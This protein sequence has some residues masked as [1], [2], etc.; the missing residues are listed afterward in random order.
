MRAD[1]LAFFFLPQIPSFQVNFLLGL[2]PLTKYSSAQ[3]G[4][5]RWNFMRIRNTKNVHG[6][7]TVPADFPPLHTIAASVQT[8]FCDCQQQTGPALIDAP[9]SDECKAIMLRFKTNQKFL[10]SI[11]ASVWFV[12]TPT[13]F[14]LL[15]L[16]RHLLGSVV[17]MCYVFT[18]KT[19][20]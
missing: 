17:L 12:S 18:K 1:L 15:S 9:D 11:A 5:R 19:L 10:T 2:P 8:A 16:W 4:A 13:P 14:C 3:T 6:R 20:L 7:Q